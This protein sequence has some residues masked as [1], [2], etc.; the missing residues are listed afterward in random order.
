MGFFISACFPEFIAQQFIQLMVLQVDLG[1]IGEHLQADQ[2]S[3][4]RWKKKLAT[5]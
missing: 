4:Y 2:G 3:L 5:S 1:H